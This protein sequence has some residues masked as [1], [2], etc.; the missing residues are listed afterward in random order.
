MSY[1]KGPR[2]FHR[3][4]TQRNALMRSL[5]LSLIAKERIQTTEAKAH[6]LRPFVEKLVTKSKNNSVPTRRLLLK[7]IKN[8]DA[9]QKLITGLGQKYKE[10]SGG[11]TRITKLGARRSDGSRMAVIEFV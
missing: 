4:K 8:K 11:Y 5:A 7:R 9:V 6:E 10:R 3:K 1:Q 2:K